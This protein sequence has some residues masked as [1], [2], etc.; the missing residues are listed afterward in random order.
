MVGTEDAIDFA[1]AVGYTTLE[2]RSRFG[3]SVVLGGA[4]VELL[5]HV[6]AY[7]AFANEGTHY[8]PVSILKVEDADGETL[9][10]WK[11][12]RGTEAMDTNIA[13]MITNVLSDNAARTYV[14]GASSYLQLGDRPVA[15]KTGTTNDYR[16]AW[17]IG[18]TPSLAA[19]VWAGNNDNSEM[20]RGAGGS[21]AAGPIWNDFMRQA[22][23]D[24]AI[25]SFTAPEIPTT[26]QAILDGQLPETTVIID[27]ASGKLATDYTPLSYRQE[28]TYAEYHNSLHYIDRDDPLGG[29]PGNPDSDPMYEPWEN[30]VLDWI[31]RQQEETGV[32]IVQGEP[33]TEYDDLHVPG[34]FPEIS[35]TS[36]GSGETLESRN[37]E[38]S[39]EASAARGVSRIE[40]Y[41][42]DLYLTADTSSPF[43]THVLLPNT[44]SRGEHALKA[45]AYD[46]IDNSAS[47]TITI[48]LQAD[49]ADVS[50]E[51]RSPNNSQTIDPIEPTFS[52]VLE[53]QNPTDYS[54]VSL[55]SEAVGS[56]SKLMA[57]TVTSPTSPFIT[58]DWALPAAGQYVLSARANSLVGAD[59]E[60]LGILVWVS[61]YVPG[62]TEEP[63]EE[64]E[65]GEEPEPEPPPNLN[66]FE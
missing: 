52:V 22:L 35:I 15:A 4:E 21:T 14:F 26:G 43:S 20:V 56:G 9:E 24:T 39:V 2:D 42:D 62:P 25:E 1:E 64:G 32:V 40:Y 44:I 16:D 30:A 46:D 65:E 8:E 5:E 53:L 61:D 19:G 3:L 13:R 60:T 57:G 54:S 51:F 10:E 66:P 23:A 6:N 7:A 17:L 47:E 37:V 50:I 11:E 49:A 33:P 34:N 12:E 63:T 58:F 31:E 45:V 28:T 59:L 36:P 41:I 29:A 38:L 48:D 55:Y 27:R 18:Y